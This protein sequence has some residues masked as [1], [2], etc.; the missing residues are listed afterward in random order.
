MLENVMPKEESIL[1]NMAKD[2]G[3]LKGLVHGLHDKVDHANGS[4]MHLERR[5]TNIE[6]VLIAG[7]TLVAVFWTV[8]IMY[9]EEIK[10]WIIS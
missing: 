4:M 7:G 8:I 10:R 5:Q 1:I 6:R 2:V 9:Q 3:E